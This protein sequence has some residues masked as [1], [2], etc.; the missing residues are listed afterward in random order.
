MDCFDNIVR[1]TF[2]KYK[3]KTCVNVPYIYI[4]IYIY[5][6]VLDELQSV[7]PADLI[8]VVAETGLFVT[9]HIYSFS[10]VFLPQSPT[11]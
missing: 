5:I 3:G 8:F 9:M 2:Q 11:N 6:L 1:E 4:Y 10:Q 7:G